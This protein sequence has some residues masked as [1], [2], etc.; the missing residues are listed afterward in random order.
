MVALLVIFLALSSVGSVSATANILPSQSSVK[1]YVETLV[2]QYTQLVS[3]RYS[4]YTGYPNFRV[5]FPLYEPPNTSFE[6]LVMQCVPNETG[7]VALVFNPIVS[8]NGPDIVMDYNDTFQQ[9]V[10]PH[11][12]TGLTVFTFTNVTV[13]YN[14]V[15]NVYSFVEGLPIGNITSNTVANAY[16]QGGSLYAYHASLAPYSAITTAQTTTTTKTTTTQSQGGSGN[17][18][19]L[20]DALTSTVALLFY[21]AGGVASLLYIYEYFTGRKILFN[22]R[23]R[24][25]LRHPRKVKPVIP[26]LDYQVNALNQ[27]L[28][29]WPDVTHRRDI[30]LEELGRTLP[31]MDRDGINPIFEPLTLQSVSAGIE[32]LCRRGIIKQ[33]KDGRIHF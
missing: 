30:T 23:K 20:S 14:G 32:E 26:P 10:N 5:Y 28:G 7:Y 27:I 13:N 3:A 9:L 21:I 22:R 15:P 12:E 24:S 4:S 18:N 29:T 11:I 25:H 31:I 16:A 33:V 8:V 17:S 6:V 1:L 2:S 19:W